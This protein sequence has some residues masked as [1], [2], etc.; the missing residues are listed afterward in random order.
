MGNIR[1]SLIRTIN[2]K[3]YEVD[4]DEFDIKR[5]ILSFIGKMSDIV[6]K[7]IPDE[8]FYKR[9]FNRKEILSIVNNS[10]EKISELFEIE[11]KKYI[12]KVRKRSLKIK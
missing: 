7:N 9:K 4:P 3:D 6:N 1:V 5:L 2:G 11:W 10:E 8:K 12:K